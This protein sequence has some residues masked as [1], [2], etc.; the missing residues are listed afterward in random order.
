MQPPKCPGCQG[1]FVDW[2]AQLG[3]W[4]LDRHGYRW[5]CRACGRRVPVASLD[6]L[7]AGGVARYALDL[8]GIRENEAAPSDELTGALR[9]ATAAEWT[10]FYYRL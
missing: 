6:W 7:R 10:Y 9:E 8:W 2:R 3:E 4:Q 1:R 5:T